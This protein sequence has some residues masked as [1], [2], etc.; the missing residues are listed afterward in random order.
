M[1]DYGYYRHGDSPCYVHRYNPT[2]VHLN[3]CTYVH[4]YIT[5]FV[6]LLGEWKCRLGQVLREGQTRRPSGIRKWGQVGGAVYICGDVH[7]YKSPDVQTDITPASPVCWSPRRRYRA[8]G[9]GTLSSLVCRTC[10]CRRPALTREPPAP[11]SVWELDRH[12][13]LS[14]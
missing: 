8:E 9:S 3:N 4:N 10:R 12:S 13:A 14:L 7:L 11:L 1:I 6:H 2:D 5:P